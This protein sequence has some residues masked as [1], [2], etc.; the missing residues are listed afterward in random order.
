MKIFLRIKLINLYCFFSAFSICNTALK[1]C[2]ETFNI[3]YPVTLCH[4]RYI[5]RGVISAALESASTQNPRG[6]D[7]EDFSFEFHFVDTLKQS[8]GYLAQVPF[9]A[10]VDAQECACKILTKEE[11][12][13]AIGELDRARAQYI[14]NLAKA[15]KLA[16]KA[17]KNIKNGARNVG[18]SS[19]IWK[20]PQQPSRTS[21]PKKKS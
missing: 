18:S 10:F 15:S 6:S 2:K 8:L 21:K 1:Y 5:N 16:K 14:T 3:I 9:T 20:K 19:G 12:F 7:V 11:V 17:E 13:E 4:C